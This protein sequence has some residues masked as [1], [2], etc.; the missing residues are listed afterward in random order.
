VAV[1]PARMLIARATE[2]SAEV[3]GNQGMP[4]GCRM[5]CI[6]EEGRRATCLPTNT[7]LL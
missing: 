3:L 7:N 5:H 6:P 2:L 1:V 4:I